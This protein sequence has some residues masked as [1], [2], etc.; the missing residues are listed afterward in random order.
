M[1]DFEWGVFLFV[2][3][4]LENLDSGAGSYQ[5]ALDAPPRTGLEVATGRVN[6]C[7]WPD[8]GSDELTWHDARYEVFFYV[9]KCGRGDGTTSNEY[10]SPKTDQWSMGGNHILQR[11]CG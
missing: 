11:E 6:W 4:E 2:G 3:F 10:Q 1:A 5:F 8:S 9:V 7:T